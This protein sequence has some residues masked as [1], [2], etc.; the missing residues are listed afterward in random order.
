MFLIICERDELMTMLKDF[1]KE[2]YDIIIQAGQ[3]NS[4]GCGF[5]NTDE[6][7]T[8]NDCVWYMNRDFTVSCAG[9]SVN[10][11]EIQS[12]YALEFARMYMQKGYLAEGRK[13]L[14]LRASVGGTGFLD[15]HWGEHDE[16]YLRMIDM[17]QTS[18][19][20]NKE[21][22]LTALLW[23]QGESDAVFNAAYDTHYKNLCT[24]VSSVRKKFNVPD[25]PFIA[26]DFVH[27]W[28]NKNLEIC[29]PVVNAIRDV[30]KDC[31]SGYFVETDG[32]LSNIQ[33][34]NYSLFGFDDTI[35]FSRNSLYKLG[36][37][38]FEAFELIRK[39]Q[40]TVR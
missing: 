36:K 2:H 37:R 22:K 23:H 4:E 40:M 20:L 31:G 19:S 33:E 8:P 28:K 5:G 35:H 21:N 14:I 9:E 12:T 3:S 15:H 30:C 1:S 13:L 7:Y 29:T 18:L 39:A 32:L 16:V 38:Y 17:I 34:N 10:G 26:G 27:Q 25:L 11:N 24:L 6:P